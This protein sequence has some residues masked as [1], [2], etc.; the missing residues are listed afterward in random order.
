MKIVLVSGSPRPN[1]QTIKVVRW[2]EQELKNLG[3]ETYIVDLHQTAFPVNIDDVTVTGGSHFDQWLTVSNELWTAD[4][5]VLATPEWNG[6]ATGAL[7]SFFSFV[8]KEM[9]FKPTYAVSVS[10]GIRG[11][12]LP[13]NQLKGALNKNSYHYTIPEYLVVRDVV[14]VMNAAEP[15]RNND[16]D[17]FTQERARYGLKQLMWFAEHHLPDELKNTDKYSSGM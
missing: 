4:G 15:D 9:A 5:Y 13:I 7:M 10:S 12:S 16:V 17:V 1:S 11:G 6:M 8:K 14:N 3:A 2:L